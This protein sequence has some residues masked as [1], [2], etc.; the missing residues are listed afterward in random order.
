MQV[1]DGIRVLDLSQFLSGPRASQLLAMFG[2]EVLKIEPPAGD[3]MR[4]LLT[5][6]GSE[7]S[8]SCLHQNKKGLVIDLRKPA[9]RD[10]FLKLVDA[11]DVLIENLTPG[12]MDK[13]ELSWDL[14]RRRNPR[15]IY[16]CISGFGK[17]GPLSDRTAF[18]I[19]SQATGGTMYGN[20]I[21]DRPPGVFFGDLCSGE[22]CAFG[23]LLALMARDK[24]GA[25]QLVDISMQ[26]VMYF[27]NF[28]GFSERANKPVKDEITSIFGRDVTRLL[29]D[30]QHPMAFWNSYRASDGY[31]AVVA[32]SDRQ[33]DRLMEVIGRVDLIGDQRFS[34]FV[35]RVRNADEIRPIIAEWMERHTQSQIIEALSE[36]RIPCG[37]VQD[38][39]QLNNDPQLEARGMFRTVSHEHL[40]VID[41]PGI[42]VRLSVTP[43]E[44]HKPCPDLGQDTSE[45]LSRVL[46]LTEEEIAKLR[47]DGAVA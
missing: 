41:V 32:L 14:L 42:P 37:R 2:A 44:I 8:M 22:S 27:H 13:L 19:I 47:E 4:M 12:T 11:S 33:W 16:A 26:D 7:R 36:K 1:L 6:S 38:Y 21:P 29:T 30:Y 23:I 18:D 43:G 15:L 45:V 3:S 20:G 17:S 5:L 28:W 35:S 25:G 39:E 46:D 24:T 31:V 10:V 34:D 9:G 40:G